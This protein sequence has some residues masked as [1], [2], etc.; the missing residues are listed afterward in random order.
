MRRGFPL[1]LAVPVLVLAFS[2]L[3]AQ[4]GLPSRV[5]VTTEAAH[6]RSGAGS[7]HP[8]VASAP[9]GTV[10]A[11]LGRDG[12]WLLVELPIGLAGIVKT[13]YLHI[14]AGQIGTSEERVSPPKPSPAPPTPAAPTAPSPPV[15]APPSTPRSEH[16]RVTFDAGL[17]L[18]YQ[19]PPSEAF[20][21]IYGGGLT[22]GSWLVLLAPSGFGGGLTLERFA[23]SGTPILIGATTGTAKIVID[24]L[25]LNVMYRLRS[26][27]A[28][29]AP[30]FGAGPGLHFVNEKVTA[31]SGGATG[32][33]SASMT[34]LGGQGLV[35]LE[36]H[37]GSL[38]VVFE[39][40]YCYA[41]GAGVGAGGPEPD[42]GG[43][44]LMTGIRY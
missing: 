44:T 3:H 24:R 43:F 19:V 7:E 38:I 15:P 21:Q 23:K 12:D 18:G 25:T 6:I 1:L 17:M 16:P 8:V 36:L 34:M 28:I 20:R 22:Y 4:Q 40:R 26:P 41:R 39:T 2:G 11:I 13:G 14:A 33:A 10:L 29:A 30:Y 31:S 32:S 42:F 37:A 5:E 9:R 35:G 27:T